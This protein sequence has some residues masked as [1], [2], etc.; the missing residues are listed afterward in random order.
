M[1]NNSPQTTSPSTLILVDGC[2][3]SLLACAYV[4]E[5]LSGLGQP[6]APPLQAAITGPH[7]LP[8]TPNLNDPTIDALIKHAELFAI[9]V[10]ECIPQPPVGYAANSIEEQTHHLLASAYLAARMGI[11][12]I[13]WPIHALTITDNHEASSQ[14]DIELMAHIHDTA[15]L[16]SRLVSLSASQHGNPGLRITTPYA[17]LS[18]TQIADL[19]LDIDLPID[20]CWWW[21]NPSSQAQTLARFWEHHLSPI[22]PRSPLISPA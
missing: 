18:A 19:V 13:L 8:F 3:T 17:A 1:A 14:L 10:V 20:T 9:N 6:P 11:Q 5:R 22:F 7:A 21:N 4:R 12:E 15:M 16:V 2:L